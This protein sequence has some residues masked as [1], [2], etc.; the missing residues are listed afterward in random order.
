MTSRWIP[1]WEVRKIK[2]NQREEE[3]CFDL[4]T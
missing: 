4:E 2:L 1:R 3:V